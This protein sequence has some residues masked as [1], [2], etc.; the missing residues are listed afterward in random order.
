MW[1]RWSTG[2][3][4]R[5]LNLTIR[6]NGICTTQNLIRKIRCTKLFWDFEIQTDHLISARRPDR[7]MVKRK[8]RIY[9]I[10]GFAVSADH[11]VKLKEC[12]MRNKYKD[13]A[14]ELK[15]L[16]HESDGETNCNWCTWKWEDE[17]R[18]SKLQPC[19]DRPEYWKESWRLEET[20][21]HSNSS[22]KPSANTAV[23]RVK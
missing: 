1:A 14:R 20:C 2:N 17:C 5:S 21:C 19:W 16:E 23:K 10:V 8:K 3:C 7:V 13:L 22:E 6:T 9:R 11:W 4:A 12:K 15:K 18:P